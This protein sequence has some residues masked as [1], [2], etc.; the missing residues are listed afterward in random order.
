ME[1][2]L[3]TVPKEVAARLPSHEGVR[4]GAASCSP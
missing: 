4:H 3:A 1:L 2:E